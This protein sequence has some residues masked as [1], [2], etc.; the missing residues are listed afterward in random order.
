LATQRQ[1]RTH[2]AKVS[3]QKEAQDNRVDSPAIATIVNNFGHATDKQ[4][5]KMYILPT[6]RSF[7]WSAGPL[8]QTKLN[9]LWYGALLQSILISDLDRQHLTILNPLIVKPQ[10]NRVVAPAVYN[11]RIVANFLR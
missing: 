4:S 1:S 7:P 10:E 6:G 8:N 5:K 11:S 3:S 9:A 2:K